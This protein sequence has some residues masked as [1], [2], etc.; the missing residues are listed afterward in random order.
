MAR[1]MYPTSNLSMEMFLTLPL[2]FLVCIC[3][4]SVPVLFRV[5]FGSEQKFWNN[6]RR[7]IVFLIF[8]IVPGILDVALSQDTIFSA[9]LFVHHMFFVQ[10]VKNENEI[11]RTFVAEYALLKAMYGMMKLLSRR[12]K[13]IRA[14]KDS[15]AIVLLAW[16]MMGFIKI[17]MYKSS[18]KTLLIYVK[19]FVDL[20]GVVSMWYVS[21]E[22]RDSKVILRIAMSSQQLVDSF[23]SLI[24]LGIHQLGS[25][26]VTPT[27]QLESIDRVL[28]SARQCCT[29][30]TLKKVAIILGLIHGI[31]RHL[32]DVLS[33]KMM[34]WFLECVMMCLVSV[35]IARD[36]WTRHHIQLSSRERVFIVLPENDSVV[37]TLRRALSMIEKMSSTE[38]KTKDTTTTTTTKTTR[39]VF[40]YI[41]DKFLGSR[42]NETQDTNRRTLRSDVKITYVSPV[43][44]R[45]VFLQR[46][47]PRSN[48]ITKIAKDS[49]FSI[50][51][52]LPIYGPLS[53]ANLSAPVRISF[54][55]KR[56]AL[57][58][59]LILDLIVSLTCTFILK[60]N[61]VRVITFTSPCIV[62]SLVALYLYLREDKTVMIETKNNRSKNVLPGNEKLREFGCAIA[63]LSQDARYAVLI[64]DKRQKSNVEFETLKM[65][66]PSQFSH[67]LCSVAIVSGEEDEKRFT[68]SPAVL[69]LRRWSWN[70]Q[71]DSEIDVRLQKKINL[72]TMPQCEFEIQTRKR[73]AWNWST[74]RILAISSESEKSEMLKVNDADWTVRVPNRLSKNISLC[75]TYTHI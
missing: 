66:I 36:I 41:R 24:R 40:N 38:T 7:K 58:S 8:T 49:A 15:F 45:M 74:G 63:G 12:Y 53:T 26:L 61:L 42:V 5:L 71:I 50:W 62:M 73:G 67:D 57:I 4:M 25:C 39:S 22:L 3:L 59:C 9:C 48:L 64:E 11:F 55:S 18:S 75:V 14:H 65:P 33:S 2:M 47:L 46:R 60:Q 21:D 16:T 29:V 35:Y 13:R 52:P 34:F 19:T 51:H 6:T 32:R 68:L 27:Q 31:S 54:L 23:V 28:P 10:N 44:F 72:E 43:S 1:K 56:N 30:A 37:R 17:W 20:A 69:I 70:R